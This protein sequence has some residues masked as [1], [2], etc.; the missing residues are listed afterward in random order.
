MVSPVTSGLILDL[1]AD[2]ITG[3]SNND[4]VATWEDSSA[5]GNDATQATPANRPT[6]QTNVL[7]GRPVVN[8]NYLN[9]QHFTLPNLYSGATAGEVFAVLKALQDPPG[10]Q[11]WS[12]LWEFGTAG[13]GSSDHYPFTDGVVYMGWGST[14]RKT[15][16]NPAVNLAAFHILN[17]SSAAGAWALR[18]NGSTLHSTGT[19]TVGFDSTPLLGVSAN[20]SYRFGGQIA[21][22]VS[23]DAVLS[24]GDRTAVYNYLDAKWVNPVAPPDAPTNPAAAALSASSIRVTWDNVADETGYRVE[25]SPNGSSGWTDV[26]GN[27][28]ADTVSYD[29]TGLTP[30][31]TYYYRVYAFNAGG[32]S[33]PSSTVNTTTDSAGGGNRMGGTGAIRRSP[34]YSG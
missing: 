25:R 2:A 13:S 26:S 33:D 12:G 11:L 6:Y 28:A 14:A 4:P 3:L 24:A 23:Y 17:I 16:G 19:N 34:R 18:L 22:L 29:D 31:T 30:A 1:D 5:A 9:T 8:F 32:D 20:T 10:N 27:L 15:C 7:N 21:E